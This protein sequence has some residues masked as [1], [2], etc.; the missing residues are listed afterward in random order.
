MGDIF[1]V[2]VTDCCEHTKY[3][4]SYEYL[5]NL[6]LQFLKPLELEF[7]SLRL[8]TSCKFAVGGEL[9]F[10]WK[11]RRSTCHGTSTIIPCP[12]IQ[13]AMSHHFFCPELAMNQDNEYIILVIN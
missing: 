4:S 12:R 11:L 2:N 13:G 6:L 10:I 9:V 3:E 5:E 1:S 7:F 8:G